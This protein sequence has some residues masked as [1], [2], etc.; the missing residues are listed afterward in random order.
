MANG[1][2]LPELQPDPNLATPVV[3]LVR[4]EHGWRKHPK[5][6]PARRPAPC[7]QRL[8][9]VRPSARGALGAA[10][11]VGSR[12]QKRTESHRCAA[13]RQFVLPRGGR[14]S[15]LN[16]PEIEQ[17]LRNGLDPD[18]TRLV[19]ANSQRPLIDYPRDVARFARQVLG[20]TLEQDQD[21]ARR[22]AEIA[23]QL[24]RT[25]STA[26]A[27]IEALGA[28]SPPAT[29][30]SWSDRLDPSP[31]RTNIRGDGGGGRAAGVPRRA[32]IVPDDHASSTNPT[33]TPT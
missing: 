11:P 6:D 14:V 32:K 1:L 5:R 33:R 3:S 20:G 23:L 30:T 2:D 7:R 17:L 9:A 19:L 27:E 13:P 22:R 24:G 15:P 12:D 25:A 16:E 28:P 18:E 29:P 31:C 8:R 26:L 21:A 10:T 4:S